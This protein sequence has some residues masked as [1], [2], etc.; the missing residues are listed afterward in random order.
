MCKRETALHSSIQ[1][2]A[3]CTGYTSAPGHHAMW[4]YRTSHIA[5]SQGSGESAPLIDLLD[6]GFRLQHQQT[7][8]TDRAIMY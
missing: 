7:S 8:I 5:Y 3:Y 1:V 6:L 2:T 4:P